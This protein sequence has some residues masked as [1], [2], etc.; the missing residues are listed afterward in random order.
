MLDKHEN[1]HV[2]LLDPHGEYARAFGEAAEIL[3]STNLQLPYWMFN[4]EELAEIIFGGARSEWES[5]ID[6]LRETIQQAK[7]RIVAAHDD[8]GLITVDTPVPYR[9]SE[10]VG[11]IEVAA[12]KPVCRTALKSVAE[13]EGKRGVYQR[14]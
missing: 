13:H 9:S 1:A 10:V 6:V 7:M 2:V 11:A 12:G 8:A 4:F 5:E 3:D 14:R